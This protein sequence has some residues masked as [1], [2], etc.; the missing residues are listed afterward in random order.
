MPRLAAN[1]NPPHRAGR[2]DARGRRAALDLGGRRIR[3]IR[4]VAFAGVDD[5]NAGRARG[6]QHRLQRRDR[7]LEQAH[8]VAERFAEAARLQ[9]VALHVDDD[10]RR[11]LER[12]GERLR[13]GGDQ[14]FHGLPLA[15]PDL[16]RAKAMPPLKKCGG[17]GKF[18]GPASG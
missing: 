6:R 1:Q 16:K 3:H 8:V 4:A 2:A 15:A 14:G 7:G 18:V 9:E 12:D 10:E 17:A 5:Q 13:F 11:T